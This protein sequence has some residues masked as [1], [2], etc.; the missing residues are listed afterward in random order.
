MHLPDR[1]LRRLRTLAPGDTLVTI[2]PVMPQPPED[3]GDVV[4]WRDND[5]ELIDPPEPQDRLWIDHR[6]RLLGVE[7][8]PVREVT[9]AEWRQAGFETHWT[10]GA[11]S[12]VKAQANRYWNETYAAR[13][14]EFAWDRAWAWIQT[15]ELITGDE[16]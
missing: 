11:D 5:P 13:G 15:R 6:L 7:C 2:E 10:V 3:A 9:V 1:A 14:P 16:R 8:K 12:I 4:V